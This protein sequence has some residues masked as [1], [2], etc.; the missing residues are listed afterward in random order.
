MRIYSLEITTTHGLPIST[1]AVEL[2]LSG[3]GELGP[4]V[5]VWEMDTNSFR[6][7][8][9]ESIDPQLLCRRLDQL[10]NVE[11]CRAREELVV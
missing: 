9:D 3:I 2:A 5:D 4:D 6:I 1:E 10:K 8:T 11:D 7:E